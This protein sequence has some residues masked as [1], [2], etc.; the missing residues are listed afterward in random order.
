MA[1][2]AHYECT[3]LRG[4]NKKGVIKPDADGAY[5]VVLGALNIYNSGGAFYPEEYAK[6]HFEENAPLMRKLHTG[7]LRGECGH[8][9]REPGMTDKD[10]FRRGATIYEQCEMFTI[11]EI[12]LDHTSVKDEAGRPVLIIMGRIIPSGPF[13]PALKEKLENGLEDVCFSIRCFTDDVMVGGRLEKRMRVIVTWDYVNEPGLKEACKYRSPTMECF[14]GDELLITEDLVGKVRMEA[15]IAG[16]GMES[17]EQYANEILEAF[18]WT[19]TSSVP[20]SAKWGK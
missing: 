10:Y 3:A 6:R 13:G 5:T 1:R 17:D 19:P 4:T 11:V 9:K 7:R 15:E 14:I 8:P 18:G 2:V 12:W 16:V 20:K